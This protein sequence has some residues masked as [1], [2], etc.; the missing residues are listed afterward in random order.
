[1]SKPWNPDDELAMLRARRWP[2][3]RGAIA[4]LLLVAAACAGFG[5]GIY[6]AAGP[7]DVFEDDSGINWS[8]LPD[9]P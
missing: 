1:M 8:A 9:Q 2:L 4:G 3:P 5:F 7:R 6:Q